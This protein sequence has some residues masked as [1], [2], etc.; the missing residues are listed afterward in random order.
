MTLIKGV[1]A[2]H[3]IEE[4]KHISNVQS[5]NYNKV[6]YWLLSVSEKVFVSNV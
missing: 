5:Y 1:A 4:F 2:D 6:K 3:F